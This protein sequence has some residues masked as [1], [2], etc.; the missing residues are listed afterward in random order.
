[1]SAT[2]LATLERELAIDMARADLEC[3][4]CQVSADKGSMPVFDVDQLNPERALWMDTEDMARSVARSVRYLDLIGALDRPLPRSPNFVSIPRTLGSA[5]GRGELQPT[6][7]GAVSGLVGKRHATVGVE[8]QPLG[9][10]PLGEIVRVNVCPN[11]PDAFDFLSF[12]ASFGG[13]QPLVIGPMEFVT[14]LKHG[15]ETGPVVTGVPGH[16]DGMDLHGASPV[17]GNHQSTGGAA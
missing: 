14:I 9:L 11:D 15:H 1:M 10:A 2:T 17:V 3:Y 13:S 12:A 4:A 6:G 8:L 16:A 5:E 7:D